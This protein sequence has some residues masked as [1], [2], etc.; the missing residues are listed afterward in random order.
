MGLAPVVSVRTV[1]VNVATNGGAGGSVLL[2]G[3]VG[4]MLTAV[5]GVVLVIA[6]APV[7]AAALVGIGLGN[8]GLVTISVVMIRVVTISV[9]MPGKKVPW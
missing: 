6:A 3:G 4:D 1:I 5:I 9:N 2:P 8:S 7:V